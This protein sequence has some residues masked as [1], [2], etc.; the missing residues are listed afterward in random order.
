[1]KLEPAKKSKVQSPPAMSDPYPS[2]KAYPIKLPV[3]AFAEPVRHYTPGT[4]MLRDITRDE[5]RTL[6]VRLYYG[7]KND[8]SDE[9]LSA[10]LDI[11]PDQLDALAATHGSI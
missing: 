2:P 7:R 9:R 6:E 4:R 5:Q 10:E 1:M 11:H 8:K 3:H